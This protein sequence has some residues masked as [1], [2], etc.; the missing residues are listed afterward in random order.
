MWEGGNRAIKMSSG[1]LVGKEM[2][3]SFGRDVVFYE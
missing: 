3:G 1:I 2:L